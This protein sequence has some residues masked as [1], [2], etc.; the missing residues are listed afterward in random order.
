MAKE[1]MKKKAEGPEYIRIKYNAHRPY[2]W[3][4]GKY[5]GKVYAEAKENKK[6]VGN[7]CPQC[8]DIWLPP[9]PVCP[10]CKIDMG[11][12]WVEL[13]QTGT[14]YQ[15]TYQTPTLPPSSCL[16]TVFFIDTGSKRQTRRS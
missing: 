1:S 8:K 16:I 7:R 14:L 11:W 10:K 5:L 4:T 12:D 2:D 13:P 9:T 15:Y 3:S 6:L